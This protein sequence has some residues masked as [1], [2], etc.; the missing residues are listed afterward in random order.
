M[1]QSNVARRPH[2][3]LSPEKLCCITC[4]NQLQSKANGFF[5]KKRWDVRHKRD[6]IDR[7]RPES[8]VSHPV[9]GAGAYKSS[10]GRPSNAALVRTKR[11]CRTWAPPSV[12]FES[13][14]DPLFW[15]CFFGSKKKTYDRFNYKY[16][17]PMEVLDVFLSILRIGRDFK[18][19]EPNVRVGS[20]VTLT[21]NRQLPPPPLSFPSILLLFICVSYTSIHIC[22]C[23]LP[24]ATIYTRFHLVLQCSKLYNY[25]YGTAE[26]KKKEKL[27]F[28]FL[29]FLFVC[30]AYVG[31]VHNV[32][33][34]LSCSPPRKWTP[35]N[36][37]LRE[38]KTKTERRLFFDFMTRLWCQNWHLNK[39]LLRACLYTQ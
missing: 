12:L 5:F 20:R 38:K 34:L 23:C 9:G 27:F 13:G 16:T 10:P 36:K 21:A 33:G 39:L 22:C 2:D 6:G 28:F 14:N 31:V 3:F 29:L 26:E 18:K 32:R 19:M 24:H 17:W 7:F 1:S 8:K 35:S 25:H 30:V 15:I 11:I 37:N 4:L